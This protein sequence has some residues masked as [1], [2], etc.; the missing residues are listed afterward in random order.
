MVADLY[1]DAVTRIKLN[2]AVTDPIELGRG[3]I[4]VDMPSPILFL[5]FIEPLLRWLQSGGRGYRYKCLINTPED[6]QTISSLAYADDLAAMTNIIA[7]MKAQAQKL[8]AFV[9][10]SG[11]TVNCKKCAITSILYG[12]A[13]RD[14]SSRVL[15]KNMINMVKDR[16][17][18]IKIHNTEFPFIPTQILT[19]TLG[20]TSPLHSVGLP[21]L[22]ESWQR[23]N[24]R[25]R[26][27]Q[28]VPCLRLRK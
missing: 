14:G 25:Q 2:F 3:T 24:K 22:I 20:L 7:D 27:S 28:T 12:Q 1:T 4:Q 26:G 8:Q 23:Q 13:H 5:I 18:Q 16:V 6:G 10:W 15:S 21:T 17:R 19:N 9:A 11:M